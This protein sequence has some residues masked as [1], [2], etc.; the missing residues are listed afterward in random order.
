[1][2]FFYKFKDILITKGKIITK[3]IISSAYFAKLNN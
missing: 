1:M 2:I 3:T